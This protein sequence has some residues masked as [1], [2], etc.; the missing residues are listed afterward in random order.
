[1][2]ERSFRKSALSSIEKFDHGEKEEHSSP[3]Y[4]V[5]GPYSPFHVRASK[6]NIFSLFDILSLQLAFVAFRSGGAN[7]NVVSGAG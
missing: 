1:M 7:A 3:S 2:Y 5:A 4:P 6:A